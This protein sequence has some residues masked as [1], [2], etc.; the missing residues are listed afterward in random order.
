MENKCH[1]YQKKGNIYNCVLGMVD[2]SRGMN[3]YYKLQLL[4]SNNNSKYVIL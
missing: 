4:E 3:T 1:V 2:V